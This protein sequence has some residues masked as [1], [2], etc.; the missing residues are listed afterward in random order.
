MGNQLSQSGTLIEHWNGTTWSISPAAGV[1]G[2]DA[3]LTGVAAVTK[4]NVWAVGGY[5]V[6]PKSPGAAPVGRTLVEH[7]NGTKWNLVSSPSP[8]KAPAGGGGQASSALQSIVAVSSKDIWAVGENT[9]SSSEVGLIEHWNGSKWMVV[10]SAVAG[11][12]QQT[13]SGVAAANGRDVWAAGNFYAGTQNQPLAQQWNGS[14]WKP[15]PTQ[16][17]N[18]ASVSL[19]EF[20]GIAAS[21]PSNIWAVGSALSKGFRALIEHWNGARWT[22]VPTP[23]SK[24]G[25]ALLSGVSAVGNTVWAVGQQ[26]R[27]NAPALIERLTACPSKT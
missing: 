11:S 3:Y 8:G 16:H 23:A 4:S 27:K 15:I 6:L 10:P 9:T 21:S 22:V 20:H 24:Y 17:V 1:N 2:Y 14:L 26:G 12:T 25:N 5:A 13:L 7:W 19:N 18:T